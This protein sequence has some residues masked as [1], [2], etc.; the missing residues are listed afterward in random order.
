MTHGSSTHVDVS[1]VSDGRN[2]T[3]RIR[4]TEKCKGCTM[5]RCLRNKQP[6]LV[7]TREVGPLSVTYLAHC[8]RPCGLCLCMHACYRRYVK[9]AGKVITK[10][11]AEPQHRVQVSEQRPPSQLH[12]TINTMSTLSPS[13]RRSVNVADLSLVNPRL[14]SRGLKGPLRR[15]V[16]S[17][18]AITITRRRASPSA[19]WP[20]PRA[21]RP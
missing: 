12:R 9:D 5:R 21:P 20:V 19:W 8:Q 7:Y 15:A 11:I 17:F 16:Q 1:K 2:G 10:C 14:Q 6:A 13:L 3:I 4:V 18:A